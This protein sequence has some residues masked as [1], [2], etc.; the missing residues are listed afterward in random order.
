[1]IVEIRPRA[2]DH[3]ANTLIIMTLYLPVIRIT[4]PYKWLNDV[5]VASVAYDL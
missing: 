1:M 2:K 5:K 3:K 4:I